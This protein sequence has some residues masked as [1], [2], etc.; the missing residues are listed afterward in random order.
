ME[1]IRWVIVDTGPLT[2]FLDRSEAH[3]QWAVKQFKR[4]MGPLLTSE[5]VITEVLF[6][7]RRHVAAQQEVLNLIAR[8]ALRIGF[9]LEEE[10]EAVRDLR[11]KYASVPMSLADASLVRMAEVHEGYHVCTLDSDFAIYRKHG[12]GEIPLI[13]PG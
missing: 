11:G 6:L 9:D 1:A 10:I 3:H 2:A 13:T 8:G 5:P 4:I 7:L 12:R